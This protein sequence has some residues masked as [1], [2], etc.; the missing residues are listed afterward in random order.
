MKLYGDYFYSYEETY[1]EENSQEEEE[2]CD[3]KQFKIIDM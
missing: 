3:P 1:G 2:G